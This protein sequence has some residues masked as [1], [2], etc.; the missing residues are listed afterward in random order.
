MEAETTVVCDIG[1]G[2]LHAGFRCASMT[3]SPRPEVEDE[4]VQAP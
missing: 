1:S 2:A 4:H 3:M